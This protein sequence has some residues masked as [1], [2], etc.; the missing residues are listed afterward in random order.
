MKSIN[1]ALPLLLLLLCIPTAS[2]QTARPEATQTRQH[3]LMP[4]PADVRF[5]VGRLMITKSFNVATR[6]QA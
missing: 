4:V 3:N 2:A 1:H 6:G 5:D